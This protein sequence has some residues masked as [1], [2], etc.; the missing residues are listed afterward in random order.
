MAMG[1]GVLMDIT[2]FIEWKK[3]GDR[4]VDIEIQRDGEIRVWAYDYALMDGQHVQSA[5]EIDIAGQVED[6]DHQKWK[7]L[8]E[9]YGPLNPG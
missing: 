7:E 8:N 5:D 9:K 1:E 3:G 2:P 6:R 4:C